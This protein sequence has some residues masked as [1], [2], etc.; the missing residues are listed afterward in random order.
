MDFSKF[1]TSD[2]LM[3]GGGLGMLIFGL[4]IDWASI[5]V[6]GISASGN[7]AFDYFFTGGIA[8]ILVVGAGVVAFLMAGGFLKRDTA[9]LPWPL[10]L[11]LATGL[12]AVLMLLRLLIGGGSEGSGG[13]EVDLDRSTGMYLSFIAV[14][15]AVV[16][17]VLNFKESGGD[18]ND[19]KDINKL[20]SQLT[21]A[22]DAPAG[23]TPPPPPPPPPPG[24]SVPP[25]PPPPPAP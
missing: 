7:N 20:K 14:A 21:G 1:K 6:G 18:L 4:F 2:W 10:V 22:G 5:D 9:N 13:F 17:G 19:L 8:W 3:I 23:S 24:G 15:V 25:P 16:G 11:L 12:G